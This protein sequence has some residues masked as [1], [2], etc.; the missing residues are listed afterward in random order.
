MSLKTIE[1]GGI[2]Y[3]WREILRLRREQARAA[4]HP[5]PTLFPLKDDARPA[6]HR[7]ASGRYES[8]SLFDDRPTEGPSR[9]VI[10]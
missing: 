5:Q 1:I 3:R 6:E 10:G 7:T 9:K 2:R 4:R 8:P